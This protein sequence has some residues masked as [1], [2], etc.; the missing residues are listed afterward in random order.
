MTNK[1]L[2]AAEA[3]FRNESYILIETEVRRKQKCLITTSMRKTEAHNEEA[4]KKELSMEN[5]EQVT[6]G[7]KYGIS[8]TR[9]DLPNIQPPC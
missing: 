3:I 4:K 2:I 5:L 1:R 6:G 7:E 9:Y 8:V